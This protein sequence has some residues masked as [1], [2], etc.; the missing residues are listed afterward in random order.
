MIGR[1]AVSEIF[2]APRTFWWLPVTGQRHAI[3]ACD[4]TA[5]TG[6][7][8]HTLCGTTVDRPVPPT[9]A[10]WLWPTCEQCWTET[11]KIV[12]LRRR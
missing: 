3:R 11:C 4:S 7:P 9:D 2:P 5:P 6:A 10:D 8:L 12:G 1:E